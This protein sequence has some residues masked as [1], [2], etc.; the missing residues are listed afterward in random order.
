MTGANWR[1]LGNI[2]IY[3]TPARI[4]NHLRRNDQ[5]QMD[6]TYHFTLFI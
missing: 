1:N 4:D 3:G 2:I 5:T 6:P